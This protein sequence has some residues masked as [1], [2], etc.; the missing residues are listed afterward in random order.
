VAVVACAAVFRCRFTAEN[1]FVPLLVHGC[2]HG[3]RRPSRSRAVRCV[4][5]VAGGFADVRAVRHAKP[6]CWRRRFAFIFLLRRETR[7]F[8]FPAATCGLPYATLAN[9]NASNSLRIA[10]LSRRVRYH[11]TAVLNILR[12]AVFSRHLV[13]LACNRL[14]CIIATVL[15]TGGA[16][17]GQSPGYNPTTSA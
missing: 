6:A 1:A 11:K 3:R 4:L 17:G 8:R 9:A 15:P 13:H 5:A 16:G 2:W 7:V 12:A 14:T 10:C